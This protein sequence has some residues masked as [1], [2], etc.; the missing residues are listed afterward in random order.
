MTILEKAVNAARQIDY[1]VY[2]SLI[3]RIINACV[4]VNTRPHYVDEV[5]G[6]SFR[7]EKCLLIR[8]LGT[9]IMRDIDMGI[10]IKRG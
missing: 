1:I 9:L 3:I 5:L 2:I 8:F 10:D 7:I 4:L 6:T